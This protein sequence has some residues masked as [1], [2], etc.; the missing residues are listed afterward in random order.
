[1]QNGGY[2]RMCVLWTLD[3]GIRFR[4]SATATSYSYDFCVQYPN[5]VMID[6]LKCS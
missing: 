1:M 3:M 2:M 5:I 4:S 6:A